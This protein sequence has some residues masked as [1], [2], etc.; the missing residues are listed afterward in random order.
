MPAGPRVEGALWVEPVAPVHIA[1]AGAAVAR[2]LW[3]SP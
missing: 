2:P 1:A 3:T